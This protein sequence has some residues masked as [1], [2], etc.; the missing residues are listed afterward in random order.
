MSGS[1]EL[2]RLLAGEIARR[3]EVF[4]SDMSTP[5]DIR[6]ALH[7]L[8]GSAAMAGHGDLSLVINQFAVRFRERGRQVLAE[9]GLML[10][11]ACD[12]LNR[13]LSP[14][15]TSW[16]EPP[17]HLAEASVDVQYRSDYRQALADRLLEL[18]S[19][20]E[21]TTDAKSRLE[22][23]KLTVHALKGAAAAVGD[24]V[25][26]WYCHGLETKLRAAQ[27]STLDTEA[28]LAELTGH[29]ALLALLHDD[30]ARALEALRASA[31]VR[32]PE[33]PVPLSQ[34]TES[35]LTTAVLDLAPDVAA[36]LKI[37][38][39]TLDTFSDRLEELVVIEDE[40]YRL[41]DFT[42][43]LSD[44]LRQSQT[45]LRLAENQLEAVEQR[46]AALYALGHLESAAQA[47]RTSAVNVDRGA[48]LL[49]RSADGL[50]ANLSELRA[51]VHAL[52][53]V[54]MHRIFERVEKA[55]LRLAAAEGKRV[56]VQ[57]SGDD[58]ALD[59]RI[60]ERLLDPL[61]Q[62]G[63]NAVAHGIE[64][65][66]ARIAAG[67][68]P[69]GN[70][71]LH[72]ERIGEWL[73]IR[74]EDDGHGAD[75]ARIRELALARGAVTPDVAERAHENDL[76]ALL[77]LPGLT[78]RERADL[79]AGRGLG[80]DLA[81]DAVR[82]LG[83]AI[84]LRSRRA[85]GLV[86]TLE[87]PAEYTLLEVLWLQE[88]GHEF[89]LPV[90]YTG[91]VELC[92]PETIRLGT[93]LG[94]DPPHKAALSVELKVHGVEPI[95]LGVDGFG[96]LEE[97]S[98]RSIPKLVTDIGPYTGAILKRDGSLR[99]ALDAPLVAARAWA[100]RP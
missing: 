49:R 32:W 67:K 56:R 61:M 74:V 73:R 64:T 82:R 47:L 21:D 75:V 54:R 97:A 100:L 3:L 8:K 92:G 55:I 29:R 52:R 1:A 4:A 26:A 5:E 68:A 33:K 87:V 85:G 18:E 88:M 76:L 12:R 15:E 43:K 39:T 69:E 45:E 98:L 31:E 91:R 50:H 16:P 70:V 6:S 89:A 23:A 65:P 35:A 10:Q 42:R 14:F 41:A 13:D 37:P 38:G 60:T 30:Q 63:R 62:L 99:L 17:P 83:G 57:T 59:K 25:T 24:D 58:V 11:S 96:A 28:T 90:S 79:V 66:E 19:S 94:L 77:F 40:I 78:T 7:A 53:R 71:L 95:W 20:A 93:C 22:R 80:L 81:Q 51:E 46:G 44:K 2:N 34:R 84:Q 36:T 48:A 9:L 86:A 27:A 72:A